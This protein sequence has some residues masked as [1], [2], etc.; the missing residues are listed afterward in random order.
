MKENTPAKI[1]AVIRP[2]DWGWKNSDGVRRKLSRLGFE[3][4]NFVEMFGVIFGF[5]PEETFPEL[6]KIAGIANAVRGI[7]MHVLDVDGEIQ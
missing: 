6:E 7:Q 3:E 2:D 1:R 5:C 4:R